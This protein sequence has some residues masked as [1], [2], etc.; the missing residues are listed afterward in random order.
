MFELRFLVTSATWL[1]IGNIQGGSRRG[2]RFLRTSIS[3]D[4][5]SRARCFWLVRLVLRVYLHFANWDDF[6]FERRESEC[7]KTS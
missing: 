5:G 4:M 6:R 7:F 1:L 2:F 3:S